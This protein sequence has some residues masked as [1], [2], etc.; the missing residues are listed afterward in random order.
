VRIGALLLALAIGG[1]GAAGG[2]GAPLPTVGP[3]V[4]LPGPEGGTLLLPASVRVSHGVTYA[5]SLGHCGLLSPVDVDGAFWDAIDGADAGGEPLDLATDGE[6]I[7]ATP[8]TI[9][10]DGDELRLRTESGSTVRFARHAGEKQF[11]GCD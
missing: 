11:P 2:P 8:G 7:N 10:V 6:M 4:G 3:Y 5:F 1:C 9:V